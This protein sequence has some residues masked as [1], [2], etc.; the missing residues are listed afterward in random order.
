MRR[1]PIAALLLALLI[2]LIGP[3][4][5]V[6]AVT[7]TDAEAR[8]LGWI[9]TARQ[10]RGLVPLVRWGELSS[11]AGS[12]AARMASLN[13]LSHT[14]AGSLSSQLN[15][16]G[17]SWVR[18][19]ETIAWSTAGWPI[20]AAVALYR[21]WQSSPPH[22]ALLMSSQFNYV[23]VGLALRSSNSRT[24][25]SVVMT[26]SPDH[27]GAIGRMGG[28]SRSGDDVTWT[29]TGADRRLQTHT[30]GLRDFDVQYR[31]S[32]GSWV[33][34][35]DNTTARTITLRDRAHGRSHFL[36]VRATDRRGNV[37]AWSNSLGIY[38]P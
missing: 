33:W 32:G 14:A 1:A 27:S 20:N 17:V 30:A 28:V 16:E 36:R 7:A 8:L 34:L 18:H 2:P 37:G 21:S 3:P 25:G 22:W 23:G 4:A 10:D 9:N 38:V 31:I 15:T 29:W 19:G 26:E 11:I 35:R 5:P 24:Y 12:R 13:Q 6:E